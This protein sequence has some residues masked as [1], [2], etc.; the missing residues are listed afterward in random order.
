LFLLHTIGGRIS[1]A[2]TDPW[3]TRYIF[4]NGMLPSARQIAE[5]AEGKLSLEDW[6]NFPQDYDRTLLSWYS[7]FERAWPDFAAQ[8]G[9]RFFRMW[10]YYLLASAGGFRAGG[11]QLWQVVFSV[12]GLPGG[13]KPSEIR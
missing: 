5:A 12:D 13:Y 3:I 7:N 11:N 8:Y 10:R 6:H 2:R 1:Q 4:P 9:E